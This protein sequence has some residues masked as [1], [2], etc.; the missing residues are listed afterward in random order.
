LID[1]N[2]HDIDNELALVGLS[3]GLLLIAGFESVSDALMLS[4]RLLPDYKSVDDPIRKSI[5]I[6]CQAQLLLQAGELPSAERLFGVLKVLNEEL[7]IGPS[8]QGVN[9]NI[10]VLEMEKGSYEIALTLLEENRRYAVE[11]EKF[12]DLLFVYF[13]L[14]AVY[15]EQRLFGKAARIAQTWIDVLKSLNIKQRLFEPYAILGLINLEQGNYSGAN[16]WRQ[17][18]GAAE[19]YA[20]LWYGDTSYREQFLSRM[21]RIDGKEQE[22]IGRLEKGLRQYADRD[23]FCRSRIELELAGLLIDMDRERAEAIAGRLRRKSTEMGAKSLAAKAE[24]TIDRIIH[25][26]PRRN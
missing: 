21:A 2:Q 25:R 3:R 10:A 7:G 12:D 23:F 16:R 1:L 20:I 24:A 26:E 22:A 11:R 9:N 6:R 18:I 8:W 17:E 19:K 15:Y 13:N 14:C 5:T 4:E